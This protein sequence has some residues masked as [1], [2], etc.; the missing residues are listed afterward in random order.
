[1]ELCLRATVL[2]SLE[3][4]LMT[5]QRVGAVLD[6]CKTNKKQL[7]SASSPQKQGEK[8][9]I[10]APRFLAAIAAFSNSSAFDTST[11]CFCIAS[12][13]RAFCSAW[14]A[15]DCELCGIPCVFVLEVAEEG[16]VAVVGFMVCVPAPPT[17]A[18]PVPEVM[19]PPP[20]PEPG[21]C[22]DC[23]RRSSPSR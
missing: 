16:L 23:R 14:V 9:K 12:L 15:R 6:S 7:A 13:S 21:C 2:S 4:A 11:A 18:P 8:K 20:R 3:S 22:W 10:N 17:P 1:M 19:L 5:V